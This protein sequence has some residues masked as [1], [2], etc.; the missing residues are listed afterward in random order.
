MVTG[1]PNKGSN[2]HI[3]GTI[4]DKVYTGH[5][6]DF[7][8]NEETVYVPPGSAAVFELSTPVPG[9]YLI[10]DHALWR[11]P[12]GAGGFMWV[13]QAKNGHIKSTRRIQQLCLDWNR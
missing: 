13:D 8:R 12:Q 11:V 2:F 6:K 1:G 3:I 5:H 4:W 9:Q 7:V 10:V